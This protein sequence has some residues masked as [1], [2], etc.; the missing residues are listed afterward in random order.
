MPSPCGQPRFIFLANWVPPVQVPGLPIRNCAESSNNLVPRV[1]KV[2]AMDVTQ[3][4]F[5]ERFVLVLG[6]SLFE[7]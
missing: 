4:I 6:L 7:L 3:K 5:F 1:T 2:S